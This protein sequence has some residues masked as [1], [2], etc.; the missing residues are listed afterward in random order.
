MPIPSGRASIG[1]LPFNNFSGEPDQDYFA[2]GIVEDLIT[3]LSR[4]KA[5][6]VVARS[7]T[8]AYKDHDIDVRDFAKD[9]GVRYVLEGSVQ[10]AGSQIRINGQ[11]VD[12]STGIHLWADRFEG[13]LKNIFEMQDRITEKVVSAIEPR[14]RKAEIER[15]RRKPPENLDAYDLFLKALPNAYAMRPRENALALELLKEAMRLDPE[16]GPGAAFAAWCYEQRV[17]QGWSDT[18]DADA[19]AA[20]KLARS[21]IADH[22][23]DATV[24]AIAGSVLVMVGHE[25]DVG[26]AALARAVE[27][28]PNS[29]LVLMN[30]GWANTF[31]GD[32]EIALTSLARA[33]ALSRSDPAEFFVLSGLAM[34]H[35]LA[36]RC[37]EASEFAA[38]S[39]AMYDAWE[40]TRLLLGCALA[41]D[42]R[43]KEATAVVSR[44][45]E[46]L[47]EMASSSHLSMLPFRD[48][49]RRAILEQHMRTA[50]LLD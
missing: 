11:L 19:A 30:H 14:I 39:I 4:F 25:Y 15:A 20:V 23:D 17:T 26:L 29:P 2:D 35:L 10:K 49:E 47:S 8:F 27:L 43:N 37:A 44:L 32:L 36:G 48:P 16:Y 46:T 31:A 13:D 28:N 50:G 24:I 5:L 6:A 40:V 33:R 22:S 34:A 9:L 3:A 21:L 41:C 38:A 18:R 42:G 7:S 1:V 12:A 45:T